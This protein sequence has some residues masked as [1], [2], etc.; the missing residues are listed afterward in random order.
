[1]PFRYSRKSPNRG[2]GGLRI[3]FFE[4]NPRIFR[5]VT[6]PLE[7]LDKM[8]LHPCKF[9]KIVLHAMDI[10]RSKSKTPEN[11]AL[12]FLHHPQK[13]QFILNWP[14]EFPLAISSILQSLEDQVVHIVIV[15]QTESWNWNFLYD[16]LWQ[17]Q[18]VKNSVPCFLAAN[19]KQF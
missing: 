2:G 15:I 7:I 10:P 14:L 1:M 18:T 4:K 11:Y 17:L 16:N 9:H 6:S 8:K 19:N 13:F 3:Y 5:L 12:S